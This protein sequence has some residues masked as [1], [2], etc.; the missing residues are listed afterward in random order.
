MFNWLARINVFT[1]AKSFLESR[2]RF[3]ASACP[4]ES[5][6]FSR[7]ICSVKSLCCASSSVLPASRNFSIRRGILESSLARNE[8]R[9][10][11]QFVRGQGHGF[12]RSS[13]IHASPLETEP[14]P[15]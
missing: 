10:D 3:S 11:R 8:F 14:Y 9:G 2:K 12:F 13:Q 1:R 7:K 15:L 6:N 5:W 4:V